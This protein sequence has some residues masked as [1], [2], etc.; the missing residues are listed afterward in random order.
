[1]RAYLDC[2]SGISGDMLLGALVDAG[3]SLDELCAWLSK[4]PLTGYEL[5]AERVQSH[6]MA[7]TR[8]RVIAA[9]AA[10][11][12]RHL[13]DILALLAAA[14]YPP[15]VY[16]RAEAVFQRLAQ[17]EAA[18]HGTTIAAVH[19]HEIGAIDSLIDIVG[20]VI[21]LHLLQVDE[22]FC[23]DLPLTSGRVHTA[24]GWLPIPAPA[25]LALLQ[26]TGAV[27]RPCDAEGELVTPTG[28]A[29]VATLAQFARPA[30]AVTRVGSGFGSRELPWANCLRLLLGVAPD[31]KWEH[32]TVA[33]LE[34]NIDNMGGEALG[35]LMERLM[36]AGALDVAFLP[37]QMKKNRPAVLVRVLSA[38]SQADTFAALL[39]R[40][41][42]TLG[43]RLTEMRR[44]KAE[45]V[46]ERRETPYGPVRVKVKRIAGRDIAIV[47]EYEDCRRIARERDIPLSEVYAA[48]EAHLRAAPP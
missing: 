2:F 21:G 9:A 22:L 3:V 23:S 13:A 16:Q 5:R 34:T 4:I 48:L 43:V 32:D 14:D 40:E 27:W 44:I 18:A 20:A 31:V 35:Y 8:V 1:M 41:T 28:A 7:G 17:A 11:P 19:F 24:H 29:I 45:R 38:P 12:V 33:V 36:N 6:G 42:T 26:G 15:A 37:M 39:I 10:Q 30:L 47:P 46:T 25:T